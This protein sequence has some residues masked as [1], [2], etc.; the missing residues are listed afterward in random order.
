MARPKEPLEQ[1]MNCSPNHERTNRTGE[2]WRP[3]VW[4]CTLVSAFE[5][6]R[7]AHIPTKSQHEGTSLLLKNYCSTWGLHVYVFIFPFKIMSVIFVRLGCC[8]MQ[9]GSWSPT[10]NLRLAASKN[11]EDFNYATAEAWNLATPYQQT[12]SLSV[13][14]YNND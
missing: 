10:T 1:Q 12:W 5:I 4:L 3:S 13:E 9:V 2:I 14:W 11:R 6:N 7:P 8:S